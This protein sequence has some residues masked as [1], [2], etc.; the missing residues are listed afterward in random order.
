MYM[1]IEDIDRVLKPYIH[2]HLSNGKLL[3]IIGEH[4]QNVYKLLKFNQL[5]KLRKQQKITE[6]VEAAI[7]SVPVFYN[8]D[9]SNLIFDKESN[10][11]TN[12]LSD[13]FRKG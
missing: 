12:I 9:L 13:F 5:K 11:N 3:Q 10:I 7:Q 6:L 2:Q 8:W 4:F 1:K